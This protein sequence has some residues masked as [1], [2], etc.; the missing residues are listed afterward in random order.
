MVA[1]GRGDEN[2][3]QANEGECASLSMLLDSV[4]EARRATAKVARNPSAAYLLAS[5]KRARIGRFNLWT[6]S[7]PSLGS[8]FVGTRPQLARA[9]SLHVPLSFV[10]QEC[11]GLIELVEGSLSSYSIDFRLFFP[12]SLMLARL[13]DTPRCRP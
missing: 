10:I 5:A 12:Y 9:N 1:V 11:P 6:K 4:V 13:P 3:K 2:A 7:A 8:H